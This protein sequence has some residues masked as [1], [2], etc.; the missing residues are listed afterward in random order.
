M[1]RLKHFGLHPKW[2]V[3]GILVVLLLLGG[4]YLLISPAAQ[5]QP[6]QPLPFSHQKH[7]EAGTQCV[8]CH[9]GV[10]NGPVAGLP[11]M[12]KCMGC[13]QSI[14]VSKEE[15][16]PD[17]DTLISM[18]EEGQPL[19]W[20]K[21]NDQPDYVYFSHRPHVLHGVSCETCHG[22]V[23]HMDI[24]QPVHNINMGFCLD[25][26]RQQGPEKEERLVDCKTCHK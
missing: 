7:V 26:H 20:V 9:P 5:A 8:Y 2:A 23:S 13:H 21:V 3:V 17:V 15:D 14:K 1:T 22:D 16:Q 4:L 6:P 24:V 10:M 25:C 12:A 19:R 18:W 11:S